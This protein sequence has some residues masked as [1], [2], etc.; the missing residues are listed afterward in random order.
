MLK[1]HDSDNYQ[2]IYQGPLGKRYLQKLRQQLNDLRANNQKIGMITEVDEIPRIS[3]WK[4]LLELVRMKMAALRV[5]KRYAI[6]T[7]KSWMSKWAA[8]AD[9]FTPG[10]RVKAFEDGDKQLALLWL[11]SEK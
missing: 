4:S 5:I 3:G 9:W 1:L 10:I 11:N 8:V 7:K 6:V 2:V